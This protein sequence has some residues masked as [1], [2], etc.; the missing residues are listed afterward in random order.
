MIRH[1]DPLNDVWGKIC[2]AE[3]LIAE[4]DIHISR[5]FLARD[6]RIHVGLD[7]DANTG[8]HFYYFSNVPDLS[9]SIQ[10]AGNIL[11]DIVHNLR[12]ALDQTVFQL[13]VN[14]ARGKSFRE[15][16]PQFPICD[17]AKDWGSKSVQRMVKHVS[18][19]SR[20][21]IEGLQP[22]H[23]LDLITTHNFA[24]PIL[25]EG[26]NPHAVTSRDQYLPSPHP[27]SILRDLNDW[28][29]HRRLTKM[30]ISNGTKITFVDHM[31]GLVMFYMGY[32]ARQMFH[33]GMMDIQAVELG[34]E[35]ARGID[36]KWGFP[37][38]K[39][40]M[41][42]EVSPDIILIEHILLADDAITH[43]LRMVK[44]VAKSLQPCFV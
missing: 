39:V 32:Q 16:D 41:I 43:M 8:E 10:G 19:K 4:Y 28:D 27:L 26:V 11:G 1:N 18:D 9:E 30:V 25:K 23:G 20:A 2:R 36:T 34:T 35:I 40:N 5:E 12:A 6:K 37:N 15:K 17:T 24:R 44:K 42:G 21:V 7:Y 22:Y 38:S 31:Q 3:E 14:R 29:K 33:N 13:S